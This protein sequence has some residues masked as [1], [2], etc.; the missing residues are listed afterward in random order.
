M[1]R[2]K[3]ILPIL[4]AV[5]IAGGSILSSTLVSAQETSTQ[6]QSIIQRIAQRFNLSEADVK[7]VFEQERQEHQ[8]Q[9]KAELETR[10]TQAV[11]DGKIN[12]EQK[13]AILNKFAD[14][15]AD[16]V[17]PGQFKNLTKEQRKAEMDQ[18]KA[19]LEAWAKDSGLTL[20]V[21]QSLMGHEGRGF[22]VKRNPK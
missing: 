2:N 7:T 20:E 12:Q 19:D 6:P 4:G 5:V 11:T 17:D 18:K 14:M 21:L 8:A 3:I 16:K 22:G 15:K 13:A 9:M 10:L 1:L